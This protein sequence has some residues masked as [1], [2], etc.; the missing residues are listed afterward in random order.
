MATLTCPDCD[1]P[2]DGNCPVC[3]GKGKTPGDAISGGFD[4]LVY[5]S[6]CSVCGGSGECQTCGGFG[7]IEIDGEGG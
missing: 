6:S 3:H 1:S 4:V 7:E 2:S 5:E